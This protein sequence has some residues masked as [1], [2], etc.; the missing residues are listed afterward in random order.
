MQDLTLLPKKTK[1]AYY[2]CSLC[3]ARPN[4]IIKTVS[5]IIEGRIVEAGKGAGGFG[6][7]SIFLKHDYNHTFAEITDDIK[8]KISHRRRAFEKL[9]LTLDAE[10]QCT[11]S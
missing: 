8:I 5:G 9:K 4:K 10:F 11:I 2:N 7:D 1:N 6:Y 3:L